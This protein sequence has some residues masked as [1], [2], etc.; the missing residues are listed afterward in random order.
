MSRT[1]KKTTLGFVEF[2]ADSPTLDLQE[3]TA[4]MVPP[5]SLEM[6]AELF[7]RLSGS[8]W[9]CDIGEA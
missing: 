6:F 2:D 5:E 8:H 9:F 7:A 3:G 1:A 4:M